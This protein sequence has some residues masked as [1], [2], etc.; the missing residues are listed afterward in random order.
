M[1][2]GTNSDEKIRLSGN[3]DDRAQFLRRRQLGRFSCFRSFS[4]LRFRILCVLP[5]LV[6]YTLSKGM[7]NGYG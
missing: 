7:A 1:N 6:A 2:G 3:K 4:Q 5:K